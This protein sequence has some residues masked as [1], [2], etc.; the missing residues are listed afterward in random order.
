MQLFVTSVGKFNQEEI[1][2]TQKMFLVKLILSCQFSIPQRVQALILEQYMNIIE[3]KDI[4]LLV[5][6]LFSENSGSGIFH[7]LLTFL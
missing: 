4:I 3:K 1:F 6:N 2:Q 7:S 5:N